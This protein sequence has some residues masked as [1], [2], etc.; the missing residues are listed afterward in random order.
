[1]K[2]NPCEPPSSRSSLQPLVPYPR[3][4]VGDNPVSAEY[5]PLLVAECAETGGVQENRESAHEAGSDLRKVLD[6]GRSTQL[7]VKRRRCVRSL[8]SKVSALPM[9]GCSRMRDTAVLP[10]FALASRSS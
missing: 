7:R 5:S 8:R 1:M 3:D 10:S 6:R 9:N 2:A 4:L